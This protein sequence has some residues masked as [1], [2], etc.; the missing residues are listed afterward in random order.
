MR[1]AP[2]HQVVTQHIYPFTW[3][4]AGGMLHFSYLIS[5]PWWPLSS[6]K[7]TEREKRREFHEG[8]WSWAGHGSR[9]ETSVQLRGED[10]EGKFRK[11]HTTVRLALVTDCL[12][13]PWR[14]QGVPRGK[15]IAED[16]VCACPSQL[17]GSETN[18]G[19]WEGRR[20]SQ[21]RTPLGK[22]IV[23]SFYF[24]S[25]HYFSWKEKSCYKKG[26]FY[27]GAKVAVVQAGSHCSLR[28][29]AICATILVQPYKI[30]PS[31]SSQSEGR[32]R[33]TKP[34]YILL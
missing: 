17:R 8:L 29:V 27:C 18:S 3:S 14:W 33:E 22:W 15:S 26:I 31:N 2:P 5:V 21:G 10:E 4:H 20:R 23:M 34:R 13:S 12:L 19:S 24:L 16:V 11:P 7:K 6:A 30:R 9:R 32:K 25:F 28:K 1:A